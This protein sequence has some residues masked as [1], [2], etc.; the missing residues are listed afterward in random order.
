MYSGI[1]TKRVLKGLPAIVLALGLSGAGQALA[2]D[3]VLATVN[4]KK[5]MASQLKFANEELKSQLGNIP[6]AQQ[7]GLLTNY[8]IDRALIIEAAKAEKIDSGAGFEARMEYYRDRA[9]RDAYFIKVMGVTDQEAKSF[10]DQQIKKVP[11][12]EEIRARHIL[13]KTEDEAKEVIK[14]LEGG[15]DFAELAKEKSTGPSKVRG[16]DLGFFA[17][18]DMVPAFFE[19]ADALKKG[20]ISKPVKTQFGYHVIKLEDRRMSKPPAFETVT[21]EIT[22]LLKRQKA[23]Q[24]IRKL[25]KEAK[26]EI[27]AEKKADEK[28]P[29]EAEKAKEMNAK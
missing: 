24:L 26:I 5:I 10:Y 14:T 22:K 28:K 29:A 25:R 11:P 19:A 20:A 15:K 18:G 13:V 1:F 7:K 3:E 9:Y 21:A 16:G 27:A 4:G 8:L 23:E 6:K 17:K 2:A 12:R